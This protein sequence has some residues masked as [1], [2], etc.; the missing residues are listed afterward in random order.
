MQKAANIADQKKADADR[1]LQE[2]LVSLHDKHTS[3]QNDLMHLQDLKAKDLDRDAGRHR[4]S[5]ETERCHDCRQ[6]ARADRAL[7]LHDLLAPKLAKESDTV[8]QLQQDQDKL[9]TDWQDFSATLGPGVSSALDDIFQAMDTALG[10][11]E[12]YFDL[13]GKLNSDWNSLVS[14]VTSAMS[15]FA[16]GNI[17]NMTHKQL[18]Q[19]PFER[20]TVTPSR[21]SQARVK[22][23][24]SVAPGTAARILRQASAV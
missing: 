2:E 11:T 22:D 23:H 5:I 10:I 15:N 7:V 21:R 17:P 3:A 12:V 14:G 24:V 18:D 20:C 8:S 13:L 6:S 16:N 1:A 4:R 19:S 9:N